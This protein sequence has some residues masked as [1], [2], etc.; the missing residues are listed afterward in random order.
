MTFAVI[1]EKGVEVARSKD[2]ASL[3]DKLKTR[4]REA[5]AR[6]SASTP[7]AIERTGLTSWDFDELPKVLDTRQGGT[8][9]RAYPAL[10]DAGTSVSITLM[11]TP[12][13]Q[14]RA[15]PAGIRRLLL[16]GIP[17]PLSYVREHLTQ[18]E[19]LL[20]AT[21]PYQNVNA[22]FDDCIVA[23]IDA[24]VRTRRP[25]GILWTRAEFEATRREVSAGLVESLLAIV[26]TVSAILGAARDAD[27][28]LRG[29]TSMSLVASLTDAREQLAGLVFPGFISSTGAAQ[30]RHVPRYLKGITARIEKLPTE[31]ARDRAWQLQVQDAT[32]KYVA[33]GGRIPLA[34]HESEK[35][36]RVRWMLEEL[37][38]SLFAQS[39]GTSET[40]SPQRIA[41]ALV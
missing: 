28:A 22:L 5:V 8:V 1:N 21:S 4:G 2:L 17:S 37:R 15:T 13:D 9:I 41:K 19:K 32:A 7:H 38:V 3:Q 31:L 39:L 12:E 11:S 14:A 26:A 25:D 29:A 30:L 24:G 10:V 33:A 27:H 36:V 6:V 40:I 34:P 20:L 35:L 18:S 16:L 23:A